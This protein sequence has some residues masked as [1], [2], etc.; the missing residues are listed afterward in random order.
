MAVAGAR[1]NFVKLAPL[2]RAAEAA[3]RRLAWIDAGQHTDPRLTRLFWDELGLPA[4][5]G[6]ATH[7]PP[8]RGRAERMAHGLV[9]LLG[10]A[11]PS[12]VVVVGDVDAAVGGA[13]AASR[14]GVPIAHV[15]AGLR[16]FDR[17]LPE[18]RNRVRVDALSAHLHV[19][20][21][22]AA[23]LLEREGVPPRRIHRAGNVLA[24][25]VRWARPRLRLPRAA[26]AR[27][28]AAARGILVTLHRGGNVDDVARLRRFAAALVD[29]ARER[30]LVFPVH[31]RTARGL[32]GATRRGLTR[33]GVALVEPLGYLE[34]LGL[35][36]E[37]SLAVTD[38]GG[39]PVEA[40][41]L[42]VPCL[43]LRARYE[44]T[45]TLSHGTNRLIGSDPRRLP[46]AAREALATPLSPRPSPPAWDGQASDRCVERWLVAPPSLEV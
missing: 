39:L 34:F 45:L 22:A 16:C 26:W 17:R 36:T 23:R 8:G 46:A 6:H 27:R 4:P 29:L 30:S 19:P 3:G 14:L 24:D 43:T 10:A 9:P 38:S 7:E 37:A 11:R 42:A 12:L 32:G 21:P 20:E 44:H 28:F 25:A 1:P 40:S 2:V 31:P 41:L 15:E 33:A 5:Q 35:L 13:L 18:E